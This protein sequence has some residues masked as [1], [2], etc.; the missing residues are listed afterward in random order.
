MSDFKVLDFKDSEQI[1][2]SNELV[3]QRLEEALAMAKDGNVKSCAI[4][5][6]T[7][8]R[9]VLD[10]WANGGDVHVIVGGLESLKFDFMLNNIDGRE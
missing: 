9:T 2:K 8:D 3:I 1:R 7:Y 6:T 5:C 4:L 10:C